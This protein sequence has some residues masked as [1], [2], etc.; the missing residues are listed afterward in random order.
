MLTRPSPMA[1]T[2][3]ITLPTPAS[4]HAPKARAFAG[5]VSDGE[6]VARACA[7]D[8]WGREV[9]FRRHVSAVTRLVQRLVGRR[10]DADDVVQDTFA[11]ALRD[12][13]SLR[14]PEAFRAWLF[15]IAVNR[16]KKTCRRRRLTRM[17]GLDRGID[18]ARLAMLCDPKA[19]PEQ[20]VELDIVD[21]VLKSIPTEHRIAWMLRYVEEETLES[22][23]GLTGCSLATAKRR[24]DAAQVTLRAHLERRAP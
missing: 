7:G 20:L 9:L 21:D 12:L 4:G 17:L 22:V 19:T 1:R 15:R 18:D 16:S 23:A 6:L 13:G 8:E 24:I 5:D 10:E 3:A 14:E 2:A 11:E